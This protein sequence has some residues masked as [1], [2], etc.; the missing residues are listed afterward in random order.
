VVSLPGFVCRN[1]EPELRSP[2]EQQSVDF[3]KFTP[4]E[5]AV[6]GQPGVTQT[7]YVG[8]WDSETSKLTMR[9]HEGNTVPAGA[10][11]RVRLPEVEAGF[12]LP[13]RL[14][15]N[16][17]DLTIETITKQIIYP[18][19]IKESPQV[20]LR[21]FDNSTFRYEPKFK[22]STFML[23]MEFKP[24]VNIRPQ[25]SIIISLPE[26]QNVLGKTRI[27][28]TGAGANLIQDSKATWDI[29]S[30][31]LRIDVEETSII[32]QFTLLKLTIQE[33]QGFVLPSNLHRN[34]DRLMVNR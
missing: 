33:S 30:N 2:N 21:Q 15:L 12:Q 13:R 27:H 26:F 10:D 29:A 20:V 11:L 24:T 34:D 3:E 5:V 28:L 18:A 9:I 14:D 7:A 31:T 32:Q 23:F 4:K 19:P 25:N 8:S 1:K 22:D 6:I 17:P 16:D